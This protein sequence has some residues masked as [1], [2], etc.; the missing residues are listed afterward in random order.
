MSNVIRFSKTGL[1]AVLLVD[2]SALTAEVVLTEKDGSL[3]LVLG[4]DHILLNWVVAHLANL[5]H[6]SPGQVIH[7]HMPVHHHFNN[8]SI[9]QLQRYCRSYTPT[10]N[11]SM[12]QRAKV[13][14]HKPAS[15]LSTGTAI[16]KNIAHSP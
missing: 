4:S 6:D 2:K 8:K 14:A 11:M 1:E 10:I 5:T 13:L 7:L 9:L 16:L 15:L 12:Q 3:Q